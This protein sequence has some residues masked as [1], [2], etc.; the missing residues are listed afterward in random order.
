M[1]PHLLALPQL[2]TIYVLQDQGNLQSPQMRW[3]A[4]FKKLTHTPI[5]I[6][7]VLCLATSFVEIVGEEI[8]WM[9]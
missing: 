1:S 7:L 6:E 8:V 9:K 4:K 5:G 3:Q 2:L